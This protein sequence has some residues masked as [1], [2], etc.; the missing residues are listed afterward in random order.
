MKEISWGQRF[1]LAV[2]VLALCLMLAVLSGCSTL[3]PGVAARVARTVEHYCVEPI[4]TRRIF[5]LAVDDLT[6]PHTIRVHCAND[7][8]DDVIVPPQLRSESAAE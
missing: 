5:R 4:E 2:A 8:T 1:N 6:F 3:S 7:F